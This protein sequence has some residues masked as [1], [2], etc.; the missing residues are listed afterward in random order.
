[1]MSLHN[2]LREIEHSSVENELERARWR[3]IE[4]LDNG[5]SVA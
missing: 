2:E 4:R 1:M 3:W 5:E